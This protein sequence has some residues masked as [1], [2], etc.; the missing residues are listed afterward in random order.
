MGTVMTSQETSAVK[1]PRLFILQTA[2]RR[3]CLDN[4][5]V[6]INK[7][8]V[9]NPRSLGGTDSMGIMTGR[10]WNLVIQMV[11]MSCKTF[12]V[13]NTVPTMAMITQFVR[14]TA[15]LGKI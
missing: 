12:V 8:A 11:L 1:Y 15:F 14:K 4:R 13:Q 7:M 3:V 6:K 9:L 5:D 10:T 2:R